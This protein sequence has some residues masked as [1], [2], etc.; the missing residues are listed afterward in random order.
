MKLFELAYCCRL[1]QH[2]TKYDDSLS[3]LRDQT[4]GGLDPYL[5]A[6]RATLFEW[7]NSWG[8]RQFAKEHHAT[9]ASVS[10]V[11]WANTWLDRLPR[12]DRQLT[13]LSRRELELAADAYGALRDCHASL[14]QRATGPAFPVTYGPTG[15][16][17]TLFALRPNV[18]APWD[19]PIRI[20]CGHGLEV[21]DFLA[22]T[23][24]VADSL[25]SLSAEAGVPVKD[26]PAI[27]NR[28][29]S[30]PPK[31]IDEYNWVVMT[32]GCTPPTLEEIAQWNRWASAG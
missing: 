18:F 15:A 5:P 27:V 31:L 9:T 22:Y 2:F 17:K 13:D 24:N 16:A 26:L 8:C 10:L 6:H 25:R 30:S 12:P 32:R 4:P 28:P 14:K 19:E 20:E 3:A 29:D 21:A 7:L 23:T 11:S 1:Y